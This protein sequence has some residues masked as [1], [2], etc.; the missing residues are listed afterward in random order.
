MIIKEK[1]VYIKKGCG[2]TSNS[3]LLIQIYIMQ[4]Q[5]KY[6]TFLLQIWM[7]VSTLHYA[8]HTFLATFFAGLRA[9]VVS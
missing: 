2:D 4:V 6:C 1:T 3:F 9:A 8:T 5:S 7:G